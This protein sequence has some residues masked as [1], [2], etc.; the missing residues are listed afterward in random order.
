MKN[1][2]LP[3]TASSRRH[4]KEKAKHAHAL[5]LMPTHQALPPFFPSSY[6]HLP[7]RLQLSFNVS[8]KT[9]F[10]FFFSLASP[11][12]KAQILFNNLNPPPSCIPPH[13]ISNLQLRRGAARSH[14]TGPV[15]KKKKKERKE[16]GSE[17]EN[18]R[19]ESCSHGTVLKA[20]KN[21]SPLTYN[22]ISRA[23]KEKRAAYTRQIGA[24][25]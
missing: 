25:T 2:K 7:I 9:S 3:P 11:L 15:R 8:F 4:Y 10:F 1:E 16:G 24:P 13:L 21:Q 17:S 12:K 20:L 19:I 23:N 5:S 6:P 18:T 14:G 22:V